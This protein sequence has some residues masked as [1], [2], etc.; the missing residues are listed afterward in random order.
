MTR[1]DS[2]S[3]CTEAGVGAACCLHTWLLLL[4]PRRHGEVIFHRVPFFRGG[5]IHLHAICMLFSLEFSIIVKLFCA[6]LFAT[7][8]VLAA[9][10]KV[11]G[12]G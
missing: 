5:Y 9:A 6:G 7:F 8:W 2:G 1:F 11:F 3:V 4:H 10:W 12:F